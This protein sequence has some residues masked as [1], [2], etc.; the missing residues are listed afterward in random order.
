[1][2]YLHSMFWILV[3]LTILCIISGIL[4]VFYLGREKVKNIDKL[5]YGFVIPND[6]IF[7]KLQRIPSYGAAFAWRWGAKRSKIEHIRDKFDKAFQRPFV[8][9]FWL[10]SFSVV[11]LIVEILLD[12]LYLHVT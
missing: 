10:F 11:T 6:S 2:D 12:K 3:V 5:V 1:M 9:T 4:L 7:Y 8:Y